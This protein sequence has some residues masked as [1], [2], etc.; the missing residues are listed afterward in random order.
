MK[1]QITLMFDAELDSLIGK[2]NQMSDVEIVGNPFWNPQSSVWCASIRD[3]RPREHRAQGI[4]EAATRS[5]LLASFEAAL[6]AAPH[7]GIPRD[8]ENYFV[9]SWL[10]LARPRQIPGWALDQFKQ[11]YPGKF[12]TFWVAQFVG[13]VVASGEIC[14]FLPVSLV[15][16]TR[17]AVGTVPAD[18]SG[19][20]QWSKT[21][22]GY[23]PKECRMMIEAAQ[24]RSLGE[25]AI[26]DIGGKP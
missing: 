9:R 23:V 22:L 10:E 18:P 4:L 7:N 5:G 21:K 12:I 8:I 15:R 3:N 17:T 26:P 1:R 11:L 19:I 2:L 13:A 16:E 6:K 25:L 24:V 14:L 20:Q